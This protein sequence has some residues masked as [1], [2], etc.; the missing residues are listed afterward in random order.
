M[1]ATNKLSDSDSILV[2]STMPAQIPPSP[3][4]V[5]HPLTPEHVLRHLAG[6]SGMAGGPAPVENL[7]Y[8]LT[9]MAT[10]ARVALSV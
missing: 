6:F 7:F 3:Y 2:A 10:T 4:L 1:E 8:H 9:P 5:N